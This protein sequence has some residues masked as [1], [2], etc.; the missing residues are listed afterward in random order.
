MLLSTTID[1]SAEHQDGHFV[2]DD[3]NIYAAGLW[4]GGGIANLYNGHSLEETDTSGSQ[5]LS[6]SP[7]PIWED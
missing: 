1:N 5:L 2:V 4:G 3:T 7:P 6:E